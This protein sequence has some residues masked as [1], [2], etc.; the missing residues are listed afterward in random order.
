MQLSPIRWILC[1]GLAAVL[2]GA[3]LLSAAA[4]EAPNARQDRVTYVTSREAQPSEGETTPEPPAPAEE[5]GTRNVRLEAEGDTLGYAVTLLDARPSGDL[6]QPERLGFLVLTP[7][8]LQRL[9]ARFPDALKPWQPKDQ[10]FAEAWAA[11]KV[12]LLQRDDG[13]EVPLVQERL[14]HDVL[15]AATA[16]QLLLEF[17]DDD[18][19]VV[20]GSLADAPAGCHAAAELPDDTALLGAATGIQ[21]FCLERHAGTQE[22]LLDERI[23]IRPREGEGPEHVV[24]TDAD[25]Y[26]EVDCEAGEYDVVVRG[27]RA[28]SVN[29]E[30][31]QRCQV[32]L[33]LAPPPP[34]K[35]TGVMPIV[36]V[37]P[38]GVGVEGLQAPGSQEVIGTLGGMIPL[39]QP[40]TSLLAHLG[41]H[42]PVQVNV[43][44]EAG[45]GTRYYYALEKTLDRASADRSLRPLTPANL[46]LEI[47]RY[48]LLAPD[49]PAEQRAMVAAGRYRD[50]AQ[51]E[52]KRLTA[53]VTRLQSEAKLLRTMA[54]NPKDL[55]QHQ[56]YVN[57]QLQAL[58][59]DRQIADK[60]QAAE[61]QKALATL[62]AA[63]Y[64]FHVV[65]Y[66]T[67][68]SA[69]EASEVLGRAGPWRDLWK[70]YGTEEARTVTESVA[71]ELRGKAT[72]ALT[73]AQD[74][75]EVQGVADKVQKPKMVE[76]D[77]AEAGTTIGWLPY[78]R[79]RLVAEGIP[80]PALNLAS[81]MRPGTWGLNF[82]YVTGGTEGSGQPGAGLWWQPR[83]GRGLKLMVGSTVPNGEDP[84]GLMGGVGLT[85]PLSGGE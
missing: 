33:I 21:G 2:L 36:G 11:L 24:R 72:E 56:A 19:P 53:E 26:F 1:P 49:V 14:L 6:G 85:A 61:R 65:R 10:D 41:R 79:V 55:A 32:L 74:E 60:Q 46:L 67:S 59:R 9:R 84:G 47:W 12:A 58:D 5:V 52:S 13:G 18:Q 45:K 37:S 71:R 28:A 64:D 7:A 40:Y 62:Q 78:L 25:G 63:L 73:A 17:T 31:N 66:L 57:A 35:A 44:H 27:E 43:V 69:A 75:A 48:P 15:A 80:E 8:S 16:P 20:V 50:L 51:A 77:P 76:A 3:V 81:R 82:G 23:T 22:P 70:R 39:L 4:A 68:L 29:V 38:G 83:I 54:D 30:P 42:L 34:F